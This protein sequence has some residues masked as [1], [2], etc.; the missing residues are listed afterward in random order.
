MGGAGQPSSNVYLR[1]SYE[2]IGKSMTEES[3]DDLAWSRV[4][5]VQITLLFGTPDLREHHEWFS[6]SH[7][8]V[9]TFIFCSHWS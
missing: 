2:L 5:T 4:Q 9:L 3:S 1:Q 8:E 6:L 7:E